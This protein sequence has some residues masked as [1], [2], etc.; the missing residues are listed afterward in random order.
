MKEKLNL[1]HE[2]LQTEIKSQ[3]CDLETKLHKEELSEEGYLAKVKSL[4]NKDLSLENGALSLTQKANGFPANG[5][6]PTWRAE[7]AD[8]NRSPRS[9]SKPR[10]PRR[11]KSDSEAICK[12]IW[13]GGS[14]LVVLGFL[15]VF[16][17]V[18]VSIAQPGLRSLSC[19]SPKCWQSHWSQLTC[20]HLGG[21][22]SIEDRP[23]E[24]WHVPRVF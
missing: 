8:S 1:L 3:L 10:G 23:L 12:D 20:L 14:W 22:G 5:S 6:R 11:S 16:K 2:F 19:F 17:T 18:P 9:R 24:P 13:H 21:C 7:M 15:V 4:L